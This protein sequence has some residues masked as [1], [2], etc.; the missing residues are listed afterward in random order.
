LETERV[1]A[2]GR[3]DHRM[4]LQM[5]RAC[6]LRI[7]GDKN[8]LPSYPLGVWRIEKKTRSVEKSWLNTIKHELQDMKLTW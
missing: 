1:K 8:S 2:D 7:A 5:A 6:V 3:Y 4:K